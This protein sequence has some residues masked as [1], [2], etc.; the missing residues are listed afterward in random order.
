MGLT[1]RLLSEKASSPSDIR[2]EKNRRQE[3]KRTRT[4]TGQ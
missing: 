2:D 3:K 1:C 4:A